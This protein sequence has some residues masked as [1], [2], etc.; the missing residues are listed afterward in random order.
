MIKFCKEPMNQNTVAWLKQVWD[1]GKIYDVDP[2]VRVFCFTEDV[3][4]LFVES[5]D[6]M[7]FVWLQ[8]I[9]GPEKAML[10]DTGFGIGNLKGLCDQLTGGRELIVVNTHQGPDHAWGNFQFE[11]VYCHEY[12]APVLNEHIADPNLRDHLYDGNGQG[13]WLAFD[14]KDMIQETPYEVV[15]CKNHTVFNLGG[16]YDIELFH[17]AG[18]APGGA[19]YLDRQKRIL[20]SGQFHSNYVGIG[21]SQGQW[22]LP[23]YEPY[24]K[25]R[26][27][28][29]SM[30]DLAGHIDEFD[31]VITAHETQPVEKTVI[32]DYVEVCDQVIADRDAYDFVVHKDGVMVKYKDLR[33]ASMRYID[34]SI[35]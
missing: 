17:T 21:I 9:L 12:C 29:D 6:G 30:A 2:Y 11:K 1:Q 4:S 16:A 3:Y 28:R 31:C 10:I 7:G 19:S 24:G 5:A 18:H 23:G 15:P 20:F 34:D 32:T 33:L 25:V 26:A 35:G 8:L 27:F 13:I 14:K 22:I